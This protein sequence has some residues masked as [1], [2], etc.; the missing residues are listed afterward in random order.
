MQTQML[1]CNTQALL[2]VTVIITKYTA[3]LWYYKVVKSAELICGYTD[4]D[5]SIACT[6]RQE[7]VK[8]G[9]QNNEYIVE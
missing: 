5:K 4:L 9:I 2:L 7:A 1:K 8:C 6:R 3:W